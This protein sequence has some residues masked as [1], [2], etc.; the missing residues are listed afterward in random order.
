MAEYTLANVTDLI[1]IS[2]KG[3]YVRILQEAWS[4]NSLFIGIPDLYKD[5]PL[6]RMALKSVGK[7]CKIYVEKYSIVINFCLGY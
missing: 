1:D 7:E 4:K 2:P 5:M 6:R 3:L